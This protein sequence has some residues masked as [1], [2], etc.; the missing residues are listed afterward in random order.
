MFMLKLAAFV[1]VA[2]LVTGAAAA[3]VGWLFAGLLRGWS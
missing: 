1:V 2:V 3:V